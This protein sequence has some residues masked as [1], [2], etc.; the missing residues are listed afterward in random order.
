MKRRLWIGC[1]LLGLMVGLFSG[2]VALENQTFTLMV[3]LC[4]TD[5]ETESGMATEDLGEMV[6]AGIPQNDVTILMG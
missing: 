1:V 4:G 2:A 6:A 3:Y 5:L